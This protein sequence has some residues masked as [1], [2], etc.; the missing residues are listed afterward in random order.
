MAEMSLVEQAGSILGSIRASV[1]NGKILADHDVVEHRLAICESCEKLKLR[2]KRGRT[3]FACLVC[4]CSYKRKV[5][6]SGSSC[7]LGKW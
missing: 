5:S 4:G 6:I 2:E 1:K 3:W 7:P